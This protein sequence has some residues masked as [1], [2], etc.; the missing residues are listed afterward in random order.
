M[1]KNY[2]ILKNNP[3]I[4]L[5]GFWNKGILT[6]DWLKDQFP[7]II[8]D[9]DITVEIAFGPKPQITLNT[10][11]MLIVPSSSR[12]V[13]HSKSKSNKT[14]EKIVK[15]TNGIIEL[16]PHTP[17]TAIGHNIAYSCDKELHLNFFNNND[18]D[19]I[20][21]YYKKKFEGDLISQR[22]TH[23][24]AYEEKKLN[25]SYNILKEKM[26]IEFNFS[27]QI[28][29]ISNKINVVNDFIKNLNFSKKIM[30]KVVK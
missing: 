25:I 22:F 3:N 17:I 9:T 28:N 10:S 15:L 16:L 19:G 27:Y 13:I 1:N 20:Y 11:D 26:I 24:V 12:L 18:D 29:N 7:S 21:D 23:C 2:K 30:D 4:V 8:T 6:P 5:V 14:N